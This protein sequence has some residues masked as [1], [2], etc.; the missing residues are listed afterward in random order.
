[1]ENTLEQRTMRKVMRRLLPFLILLYFFAFLDRVNVGFAA[2]TMNKAI[3]LTAYTFGWGAGIFFLSYFLFEVPSTV[4]LSKF[5]A[6]IWLARI[7]MTWGV[8]SACGALVSGAT[9]FM[10]VRFVLGAAEAGFFPGV[11]LFLTTWFPARYRARVVAMFMLANPISTALGSVV[12]SYV[13]RLDGVFNIAGWQWL[14]VVEGLPSVV[15]GVITLRYLIDSPKQATWLA[16]DERDWLDQTIAAEA[17]ER[18]ARHKM[19][20][21]QAL[22]NPHVLILGFIYFA[23]VTANNGLVLWQ[24][25]I[26]KTLVDEHSIG[27]VNAVPFTVGALC[28][29]VWGRIVDKRGKY[30]LDLALACAIIAVGLIIAASSSTFVPIFAGLVIAAIGGYCALPAFWALPTAFLSGT[31]AAAG[32]ALVNSIGNL[33]GFAGPYLLGYLRSTTSGHSVGM[34]V[35]AGAAIAAVVVTLF[36]RGPAGASSGDMSLDHPTR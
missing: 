27:F 6:R 35:L 22:T 8:V 26:L 14:F 3:G 25:Q 19:S 34:A 15:L 9:S 2:L 30:R 32:I 12:S 13:L 23:I 18:S 24:P 5:G 36:A 21:F 17:A 4:A 20:V 31:A 28:M 33:G 1:M 10:V 16:N 29:L 7:M 11:I